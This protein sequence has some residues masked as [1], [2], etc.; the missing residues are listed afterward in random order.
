[1]NVW[2]VQIL[3][4]VSDLEHLV[5]HFVTGPQRVLRDQIDSG[6][7]Y[8]SDVFLSENDPHEVLSLA[9]AELQVLSGVLRFTRNSLQPLK[10]GAV[11]RLRQD[12]VRDTFVFSHGVTGVH[13]EVGEPSVHILDVDGKPVPQPVNI[14]QSVRLSLLALNDPEVAKAMRLLASSTYSKW[15]EMY[16][17][18]EVVEESVGGQRELVKRNWCAVD[19]I[20]RFKHTA[21]SVSALGDE[22]RHGR[23]DTN[24]P[25][26]PMTHDEGTA[27]LNCIL[28]S[29]FAEKIAV[30]GKGSGS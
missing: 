19:A 6:F 29:W 23:E 13:I 3:G 24:P 30:S 21:N 11:F 10:A 16:R 20:R 22:S 12:G 1:M 28:Q 18:Y 25:R 7:I 5:R 14:P 8:E 27:F 2:Q 4:Y 15:V 9:R 17:L 26:D